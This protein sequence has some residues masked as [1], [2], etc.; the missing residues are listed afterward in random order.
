MALRP[1]PLA[2]AAA[3]L[4]AGCSTGPDYQRP[5]LD[6]PAAW[7]PLPDAA[8]PAAS[9][10]LAAVPP[11]GKELLD[12][13]WWQA[14][15]DAELD[16]LVNA[17]VENNTDLRLAALRIEQLDA[18]LQVS[19]A[20][21]G[22]QAAAAA[23]RTRDTLSENRQVPLAV[24]TRPVDN[25]YSVSAGVSWELDL[26]GKVARSN[27]A[28]Y[29]ELVASEETRRALM[30]SIVAEVARGYTRLVTL[31]RQLVTL[32]ATIA[33]LEE[34]WR[35]AQAKFDAGG[36]SELPVL[37]AKAEWQSRQAEVPALQSEIATLENALSA[38]AGRN[39]GAV[40]RGRSADALA[41]PRVPGGL[42]ADLLAQ[43]PDVRKAE[44]DLVAANARIGVA[45][46]QYYP[47]ISLTAS[48]GFAS[49]ELSKLSMLTSNF[50]SFGVELLGPLF[51]S[52]RIAGQVKQAES[53]Q[54]QAALQFAKAMQTAV[55]EVDDALVQQARSGEQVQLRGVQLDTLREQERVARRRYELGVGMYGDVLQAQRAV[56]AGQQQVADSRRDQMQALIAVYKAMGGG[57]RLPDVMAARPN[58]QKTTDE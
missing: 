25:A 20:A 14:F 7:R 36:S 19:K 55:R 31:D 8:A 33:S 34:S 48:S 21:G 32:Q 15:G 42:P 47:N 26:W 58:S 11:A 18:A 52:G 23:A 57:W 28:A 45:K 9:G 6:L 40:A 43:R 37:G 50:G 46:A 3:A 4:V 13:A 16:A 27:E 30:Q 44:Q 51:T 22:P 35:L 12:T 56:L 2:L 5:A 24:G 53:L 39:P 10:P 49:N 41:L 38:L 54:Q 17:A 1:L 29:A